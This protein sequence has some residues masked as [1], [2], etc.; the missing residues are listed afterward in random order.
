MPEIIPFRIPANLGTY[1]LEYMQT[2]DGQNRLM[3][4]LM[5]LVDTS[6]VQTQFSQAMET[7]MKCHDDFF[8][9]CDRK[10]D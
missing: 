7:Y 4:G 5:T 9:R 2:E 8:H 6:E 10:G 3:N 1:F